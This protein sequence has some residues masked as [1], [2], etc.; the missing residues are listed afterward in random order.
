MGGGSSASQ[1]SNSLTIKIEVKTKTEIEVSCST[2]Q[3]GTQSTATA[4]AS[5]IGADKTRVLASHAARLSSQT[6]NI[7]V[8]QKA[9]AAHHAAHRTSLQQKLI[10]INSTLTSISLAMAGA[11]SDVKFLQQLFFSPTENTTTTNGKVKTKIHVNFKKENIEKM[12]NYLR[13]R[14]GDNQQ[15]NFST[16]IHSVKE[17]IK[18]VREMESEIRKWDEYVATFEG[19]VKD[20]M[21]GVESWIWV[22]GLRR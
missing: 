12:V 22:V 9:F 14:A 5:S 1:S 3:T 7:L 10:S 4:A 15:I 6:K 17:V 20:V 16:V 19:E 2:T 21:K 11:D 8:L 13:V 18:T